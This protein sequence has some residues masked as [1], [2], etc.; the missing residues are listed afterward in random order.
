MIVI[1][2]RLGLGPALNNFTLFVAI[3]SLVACISRTT[4]VT[5]L[6]GIF[7]AGAGIAWSIQFHNYPPIDEYYYDYEYFSTFKYY[8]MLVHAELALVW[9]CMTQDLRLTDKTSICL[10]CYLVFLIL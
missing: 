8:Y 6:S 4:F 1:I 10:R 7:A 2:V 5:V 3:F 9:T